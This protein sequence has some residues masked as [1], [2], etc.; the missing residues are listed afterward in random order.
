MFCWTRKCFLLTMI[1]GT[2]HLNSDANYTMRNFQTLVFSPDIYCRNIVKL[3][4]WVVSPEKN[5]KLIKHTAMR[6][7]RFHRMDEFCI[8]K[9]QWS[10]VPQNTPAPNYSLHSE[11]TWA[12]WDDS[13]LRPQRAESHKRPAEG[14]EVSLINSPSSPFRQAFP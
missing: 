14:L 5:T 1:P 2:L 7:T 8:P 9:Q 6:V 13:S 11:H 10:Q 12:P 4:I 3:P